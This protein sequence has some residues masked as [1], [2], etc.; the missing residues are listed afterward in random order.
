[1]PKRRTEITWKYVQHNRQQ[2][3]VVLGRDLCQSVQIYGVYGNT[4]NLYED[5]LSLFNDLNVYCKKKK[6]YECRNCKDIFPTH[7]Q[8]ERHEKSRK[9]ATKFLDPGG[10]MRDLDTFSKN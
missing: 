9:E 1:M 3:S 5:H 10:T 2:I 6:K 7:G 8:V 4:M